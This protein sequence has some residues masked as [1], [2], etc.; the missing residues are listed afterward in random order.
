MRSEKERTEVERRLLGLI[1]TY[2][3]DRKAI[4]GANPKL[5]F[6][7]ALSPQR[8]NLLE[9][10]PFRKEGTLLQI[11]SDF[12]ALTGLYARKVSRVDVIDPSWANL[13]ISRLRHCGEN[14]YKNINY[15]QG[16]LAEY[17]SQAK[18]HYDYI[19]IIGDLEQDE[20]SG[21]ESETQIRMAKALLKPD[22]ELIAAVCNPL[23]IK[24]WAGAVKDDHSLSKDS[25][26]RWLTGGGDGGSLE[27]YYPM[28]D[29]RLPVTIYSDA[30]L[31]REGDLTDTIAAYDF[32]DYPFFDMGAAFD[33][34]V[35]EGKFDQYANAYLAIWRRGGRMIQQNGP[36]YM[37]YN[38]TRREEFQLKTM[39]LGGAGGECQVEKSALTEEA[40]AHIGHFTAQYEALSAQHELLRY[41]PGKRNPDGSAVTFPYLKGRTLA[42]RLTD[43]IVS[44]QAPI[45]LIRQSIDVLLAA[46]LNDV[47]PFAPTREFAEV[48]GEEEMAVLAGSAAEPPLDGELPADGEKPADAAPPADGERPD[49]GWS[50]PCFHVSNIDLL[51]ENVLLTDDGNYC[52]DYEWVFD[53]PVPVDYIR[54]RIL[55]YAYRQFKSLMSDCG[56]LTEW[57][58]KFGIAPETEALYASMEKNFQYYVHGENQVLY[59]EN[60]LVKQKPAKSLTEMDE[61]ISRL[62]AELAHA[63]E[64]EERLN[65]QIHD[66]NAAIRKM[67]EVKR[68]TDNHVTNLE[69]IIRDLRHEIDEMGRTLT[70]LNGHEAVLSK[71]RRK[72][73]E[74]FNAKYPKG[75]PQRK[76]LR[77]RKEYMMHPIRS[78]KFY[79]TEEGKNMRDGDLEIGDVYREHGKLV[80]QRPEQPEVSIVIPA[81]NQIGYTYACLISILEHTKDVSYEVIIADDMSTDATEHIGRYVEGVTVSRGET[82]QGFL[83]NC[84]RAAKLARGRYIMFLNNDTQVTEGWLSSL[85]N[86]IRSDDTI[87]MVGSK[88]V[89]PDG[90]LQEAGGII[91]SDG[92]GWNYGRLDDPDKPEYNYVK[93]VD[94]ISGAA[95]LLPRS[96]WEQIGGFDERYAPAYCEDSD[97]AFE[98]RKAGLR[99]VYQPLSRVIHY[100]GISNG[101]D[102]QGEGL[103]RY[104]VENTEKLKEKWARELKNQCENTGNPDPF[105]ARERSMGRPIILVIDHYVPT[106]DKDAGS[107]TTYQYLK[108]FL[109][110]GYTVKFLGDNFAHEE[111]YSTVL[112]QMGIEILYGPEYEA[113]IWDWI[114]AHGKD[115][116]VAYL[117]RPHIAIKYVDYLRENTDIKLIYYGH[118]LHYLRESREYALTMDPERR[119]SAEYWKAIEMSLFYK[120]DMSYYP[121]YV[122]RDAVR[123][124]DENIPVKDIVAYVYDEFRNDIP[125]DFAEREGI[126]FVGGFA[127]PPNAD[128]V[129]WFAKEVYPLIVSRM[130]EAGAEPPKFYVAGS[131]VTDEIR[132]LEQT[133]PGVVVKGFVSDEELTRLYDATRLVVVPL[134]YGAGVKGKVVEALY[135]GAAVVTTPVGAEGIPQAE[136]VMVTADQAEAFAEAVCDIYQSPESCRALSERSQEYIRNYYSMD[137]AWS[138]IAEDFPR[139]I[140]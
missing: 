135:N 41:L 112:E 17:V 103:K 70:Y 61:E 109:K 121:S 16:T 53:F 78:Y 47:E 27:F 116:A 123:T 127:H 101:T 119:K 72:L 28:P 99:V 39:I 30:Y 62:E 19:M 8:E 23:G 104:Q 4:L 126:L 74:K 37:K 111:P 32:P 22:G 77:Y 81:Y 55:F 11:G 69:I 92:S 113:G 140:S 67:T 76:Q 60:Y 79:R 35:K 85:V 93:D 36:R 102:V 24:Y 84:N 58:G 13:E 91:W 2:G 12:G 132:A 89:Y 100:E 34:V 114:S 3:A 122:E 118:D 87:G 107:K 98:V 38:R 54:Y 48:F 29:Y 128:A 65:A 97:L 51:F 5:E 83:R 46:R 105:R 33:Q 6:L 14:G 106:F 9:W 64:V 130:R 18:S 139:T 40:K 95:I 42:A 73:G 90:R 66:Q 94:Y 26:T 15:V 110:Q 108:M 43:E 21:E 68:L 88:L 133:V 124:E 20:L 129:L 137:A 96:L 75:S 131:R 10:Y 25:L 44:G 31:P 80:F 86:L 138:V 59:L 125:Q 117:N 57:L 1:K 56:T 82:N 63:R 50:V 52:L 45:E 120:V 134:R 115:I 49:A 7:Y 71:I 136:D